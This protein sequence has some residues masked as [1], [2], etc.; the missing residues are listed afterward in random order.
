MIGNWHVIP[1]T[2]KVDGVSYRLRN[3]GD[4]RVILDVLEKLKDV[5]IINNNADKFKRESQLKDKMLEILELAFVDFD[6]SICTDV[7]GL[8]E[9]LFTFIRCYAEGSKNENQDKLFDWNKDFNMIVSPINA[10]LGKDVRLEEYMHWF[11]F[12]SLFD[13]IGDCNFSTV[14]NLR[15]KKF[16]GEKLEKSEKKYIL[17]N[18]HL[19]KRD[20]DATEGEI[21]AIIK[22]FNE[23]QATKKNGNN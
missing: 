3:N 22:E 13:N 21:K 4:Y 15:R 19:F 5:S 7:N 12:M 18:P 14:V 10:T 6:L 1:V 20:D 8:V 11:T 17:E 2:L 23:Y 9:E 16:R